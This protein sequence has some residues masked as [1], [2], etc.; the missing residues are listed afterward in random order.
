VP[1]FEGRLV[2][3]TPSAFSLALHKKSAGWL[4]VP[5]MQAHLTSNSGESYAMSKGELFP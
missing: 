1:S 3:L 5:K 4:H 2:Q